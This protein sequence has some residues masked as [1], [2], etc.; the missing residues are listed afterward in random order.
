RGAGSTGGDV[1]AH[2]S[3][4]DLPMVWEGVPR[5]KSHG[6]MVRAAHRR[7]HTAPG[8]PLPGRAGLAPDIKT[9]PPPA[10][11]SPTAATRRPGPV[12]RRAT[13]NKPPCH[14]ATAQ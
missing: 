13:R 9:A 10:A 4:Q 2:G 7:R 12:P 1:T 3:D 14:L 11:G 6:R 5:D 8:L